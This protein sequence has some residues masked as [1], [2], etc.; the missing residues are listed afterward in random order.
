MSGHSKMYT[1]GFRIF[2]FTNFK[3]IGKLSNFH[4]FVLTLTIKVWDDS[5]MSGHSK[6]YTSGYRRVNR[7]HL[8]KQIED[9]N[10]IDYTIL[11]TPPPV[12]ECIRLVIR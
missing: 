7:R 10:D 9:S 12:G 4:I 2:S 5:S 6:M 11:G 8:R 3:K 1:S